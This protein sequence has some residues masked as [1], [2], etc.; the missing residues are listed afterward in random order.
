[1]GR[2]NITPNKVE[3]ETETGFARRSLGEGGN[4]NRNR[5][6]PPE[7]LAKAGTER[8]IGKRIADI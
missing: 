6:C 8:G 3:T 2:F 1:M 4:R 5:L 7:D